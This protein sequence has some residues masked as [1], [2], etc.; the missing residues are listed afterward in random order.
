M[1]GYLVTVTRAALT[2]LVC[3]IATFVAVPV[4]HARVTVDKELAIK[5]AP[6]G[7]Q[8]PGGGFEMGQSVQEFEAELP[9]G[10]TD[11]AWQLTDLKT[12]E[13]PGAPFPRSSWQLDFVGLTAQGRWGIDIRV[14]NSDSRDRRYAAA[15]WRLRLRCVVEK[16]D[17]PAC[18]AHSVQDP[19][20]PTFFAIRYHCNR[21]S[22]SFKLKLP[23]EY[24]VKS[25]LG[26][27]NKKL[28]ARFRCAARGRFVTCRGKTPAWTTTSFGAFLN[29]PVR[30]LMP[31]RL[32]VPGAPDAHARAQQLAPGS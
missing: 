30:A 29:E 5:P 19:D 31:T 13:F 21:A 22:S 15:R 9:E 7:G 32:S 16:A 4:A 12:G 20:H 27:D 1:R 2:V 17:E 14:R 18:F 10:A 23:L 28:H 24:S 3:V 8:V 26:A 6:H 25:V 11:C